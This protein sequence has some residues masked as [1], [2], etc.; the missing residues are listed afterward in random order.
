VS[1]GTQSFQPLGSTTVTA[2]I[3]NILIDNCGT[4]SQSIFV[5]GTNATSA[6][7][8]GTATWTLT[9]SPQC[10]GA[11]EAA[12]LN[13]YNLA[14]DGTGGGGFIPLTSSDLGIYTQPPGGPLG[15]IPKIGCRAQD[16]A[17]RGQTMSMSDIFTATL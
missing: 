9:S 1:F 4:T 3:P 16:R 6:S 15:L 13:E 2:G 10:E 7:G 12:V 8:G 11:G 17:A 14:V 5:R